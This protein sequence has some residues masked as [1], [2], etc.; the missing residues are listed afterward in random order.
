MTD[1]LPLEERLENLYL[2]DGASKQEQENEAQEKRDQTPERGKDTKKEAILSQRELFPPSPEA[3]NHQGEWLLNHPWQEERPGL[4]VKIDD[5]IKQ[6]ARYPLPEP[7]KSGKTVINLGTV[8]DDLPE[9]VS[10][11]RG[12]SDYEMLK[13]YLDAKTEVDKESKR[14]PHMKEI[15]DVEEQ[16]DKPSSARDQ[17][18][19]AYSLNPTKR[20]TQLEKNLRYLDCEYMLKMYLPENWKTWF[21]QENNPS[22][23]H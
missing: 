1:E 10:Q 8:Y 3:E 22:R 17:S 6:A 12:K 20:E 21:K 11:M 23:L 9:F 16:R 15:Y 4:N 5:T 13:E 2:R 18:F 7:W 14:T 19:K